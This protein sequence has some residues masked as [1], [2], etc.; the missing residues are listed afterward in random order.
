MRKPPILAA[1]AVLLVVALGIF[2][3]PASAAAAPLPAAPSLAA[4]LASLDQSAMAAAVPAAS[5]GT[6][7]CTQAQRDACNQQCRSQGHTIF[8]G[9][10]C[11][12]NCT[13]LCICGSKPVN[14]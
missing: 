3:P 9:L 11:C 7:F 13:T 2:A 6:N 12:R 1:V 10:E 14:C 4:F 5:C 8:V